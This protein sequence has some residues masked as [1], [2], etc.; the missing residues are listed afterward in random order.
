MPEP[1]TN[2]GILL[3][4]GGWLFS[5]AAKKGLDEV[6][7]RLVKPPLKKIDIQGAFENAL[8]AALNDFKVKYPDLYKS[9]FDETFIEKHAADELFKLVTRTDYPKLDAI[10]D[11]FNNYFKNTKIYNIEEAI[12]Y[13]IE[14]A[15]AY[16]KKES[17]LQDLINSRQIEQTHNTVLS[18]QSDI[19]SMKDDVAIIAANVKGNAPISSNGANLAVICSLLTSVQQSL[20]KEIDHSLDAVSDEILLGNLDDCEIKLEN[21]KSGINWN[22]LMPETQ[23]R[24]IRLQASL[25][26]NRG[27]IDSAERLLDVADIIAV[28]EE[29][30]IRALIAAR[31]LN[32]EDGLKVLGTPTSKDGVQLQVALLLEA[33]HVEKAAGILETHAVLQEDHAETYRLKSFTAL[34]QKDLANALG[35]VKRSEELKPD[36][37]A[38]K[39]LGAI[40][41]YARA[42]SPIV[43]FE[44]YF[45]NPVDIDL[46]RKDDNSQALLN[47]AYCRF[48][49][50]V[51]HGH[52]QKI[53]ELDEIWVLACLCNQINPAQDVQQRFQAILEKDLTNFGAIQWGLARHLDFDREDCKKALNALLDVG[54]AEPNHALAL[55]W[56]LASE[57]KA[58]EAVGILR[59]YSSIFT[60]ADAQHLKNDLILQLDTHKEN[61]FSADVDGALSLNRKVAILANNISEPRDC[62]ELELLFRQMFSK[63]KP[64]AIALRVAQVLASVD[65]WDTISQYIDKLIQIDTAEAVRISAYA[66]INSNRPKLALQILERHQSSFPSCSLPQDLLKLQVKALS[67]TGNLPAALQKATL[68]AMETSAISDNLIKAN[69]HLQSGNIGAALPIIREAT[70]ADILSP[71]DALRLAPL[72][73]V[74]DVNLARNLVRHAKMKG[75]PEE[76]S[77]TALDLIFR[78]GI[79]DEARPLLEQIGQLAKNNSEMVRLCTIDE[80]I[81]FQRHWHESAINIYQLY[82]DGVIPVHFL[83]ERGGARIGHLYRIVESENTITNCFSPLMVRHGGRPSNIKVDIPFTEWNIYLDITGLLIAYQLN[84]LDIIEQLQNPITISPNLPKSLYELEIKAQHN[85]PSRVDVMKVIIEAIDKRI[86]TAIDKLPDH[87]EKYGLDEELSKALFFAKS[88]N[89]IIIDHH[90]PTDL[91]AE[92]LTYFTSIR[93]IIDGLYNAGE[94]D[95]LHH[96]EALLK[97][98]DYKNDNMGI[99]PISGSNLYFTT[100]TLTVI[101]SANL[102]D[103]VLRTYGVCVDSTLTQMAHDEIESFEECEKQVEVYKILRHRISEGMESGRYIILPTINDHEYQATDSHEENKHESLNSH[104]TKCLY[105]LLMAP[106]VPNSV[107]WIDDRNLSGYQ[108]VQP[109]GG[110]IVGIYEV[111]SS[112]RAVNLITEDTRRN[113]LLRLRSSGFMFLPIEP[114]EVLDQLAKARIDNNKVI[115][116]PALAIIRRYIAQTVLLE[117]NLKIDDRLDVLNGRPLEFPL[118]MDVRRL[119][120]TC[121]VEQWTNPGL[122]TD[123]RRARSSW[124]WSSLRI[125]KFERM[126]AGVSTQGVNRTIAALLFGALLTGSMKIIKGNPADPAS[127]RRKSYFKWIEDEVFGDRLSIDNLLRDEI[128]RLCTDLL[129]NLVDC[130][131][132]AGN[133]QELIAEAKRHLRSIVFEMPDQFKQKMLEN[134]EFCRILGIKMASVVNVSDV[135]FKA[136]QFW[137]TIDRVLAHGKAKLK[138]LNDSKRVEFTT[139]PEQSFTVRL[140]GAIRCQISDPIFGILS[141]DLTSR[142]TL[143]E[144]HKDWLDIPSIDRKYEIERIVNIDEPAERIVVLGD[145]RDFSSAF[146]YETLKISFIEG[147]NLKF[148]DMKPLSVNSLFNHLRFSLSTKSSINDRLTLAAN[149]LIAEGGLNFAFCRLAGLPFAIPT[150][151]VSAFI[152]MPLEIR[153]AEFNTIAGALKTPVQI[154][155]ALHLHRKIFGD[156]DV[157]K[158]QSLFDQ[159]LGQW[160]ITC[161]A[162]FAI[163]RWTEVALEQDPLWPSLTADDRFALIWTHTDRIIDIQITCDVDLNLVENAF[164]ENNHHQNRPIG[165]IIGISVGYDDSVVN[166]NHVND[167][168]LLY[169]GVGYIFGQG[170]VSDVLLPEQIEKLRN[171]LTVDS[172]SDRLVSPWLCVRYNLEQSSIFSERPKGIFDEASDISESSCINSLEATLVALESDIYSANSWVLFWTFGRFNLLPE[173]RDRLNAMLCKLDFIELVEREPRVSLWILRVISDCTIRLGGGE[174]VES[175]KKQLCRL[176]KHY[177]KKYPVRISLSP[178]SKVSQPAE[179]AILQIVEGVAALVRS[180]DIT[181]SVN[182]LANI[183][184]DIVSVWPQ[185][186]SALRDVLGNILCKLTIDESSDIWKSYITIRALP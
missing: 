110:P 176:S 86:I 77:T 120:E 109:Q 116:T 132:A 63:D 44:W 20:S 140:N 94:L 127:A 165:E 45:P 15:N 180:S 76:L 150:E 30:R 72:V 143:L 96:S 139:A 68:L 10:A 170:N 26:L 18:L 28:P 126:P 145:L 69:L 101:A 82:L 156:E 173:Y 98:G 167:V 8:D 25:A 100:N 16:I 4:F 17:K 148:D 52:N 159:L 157:D 87:D 70:R 39:R 65:R 49:D 84:L 183:F 93:A 56:L 79:E 175:I 103:A 125:E 123:V 37:P 122:S 33:G 14:S 134:S 71:Y 174:S 111:L 46:V 137:K 13:F 166:P 162:F 164:T 151:I 177:S 75:I 135:S 158:F 73:A 66:A 40:V 130:R 27:D 152:A 117:K 149:D 59:D 31:R 184:M 2:G 42:L 85:Q 19:S 6:F 50:L 182:Q 161:K 62:E 78:L 38:V 53:K 128:V 61:Y 155:H 95:G 7:D 102:L 163:L 91:A 83:T 55:T 105:D 54:R 136:E 153:K 74:E 48:E 21:I 24:V 121:I 3:K 106:S 90:M 113:A 147:K 133:S 160:D 67:L 34:I 104:I 41:R 172:N 179:E 80:L 131:N 138:T 178:A 142:Q 64:P 115:E 144:G 119:A 23:A 169:Y 112:M 36:W 181:N 154:I 124:L 89:C 9:L 12:K 88:R 118:I 146:H 114:G 60:T 58:E 22:N 92:E 29:P 1:V 97:I 185:T 57:G 81:E 51:R 171:S 107:I 168:N 43:D 99:P 32:A 5:Y 141:R 11:A 35:Y 186:A 47:E 108:N 129:I